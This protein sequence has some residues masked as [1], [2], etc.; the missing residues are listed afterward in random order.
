MKRLALRSF[1]RPSSFFLRTSSFFLAFAA[2]SA[3]AKADPADPQITSY[4]VSQDSRRVVSVAY[5]LDEPA[6]VTMDVLTNGVSIGGQNI[7]NVVGDC[8]KLVPAGAHTIQW[9][10]RVS[11]PD[12]RFDGN[13]VTV[14]LTASA[15]DVP[16][17]VMDIDLETKAVAYYP[18]MDYLPD[19]GLANDKYRTTH[20]V[21][22][23]V[24]AAGQTFT[25]GSPTDENP[26]R[27]ATEV[28]HSVSFTKDYYL[29]IYETT[30]KQFTTM[31]CTVAANY[32]AQD[33]P[34]PGD[35]ADQTPIGRIL[36]NNLRGTVENGIDWPGTGSTVYG[37]S[38][39]ATIRT[40]TG[41][42][43]DLPTEAQ[44]EF[45]CRAGTTTAMYNGK[46][47]AGT[48][49][50]SDCNDIAWYTGTSEQKPHAVGGKLPNDWGFY[51][52]YGN[53]RE[54][55]LDWYATYPDTPVVDPNGPTSGTERVIRSSYYWDG[56]RG[57]RS[58]YRTSQYPRTADTTYGFRLCLPL[59]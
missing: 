59:Q 36:Y 49:G 48:W 25:M 11:W 22:K 13:V 33:D 54:W 52:M 31:G 41:L 5:T 37:D 45:A 12:Q 38:Y 47:N 14:R 3:T 6:Y 20:L 42:A 4:T 21:M 9:F 23:K 50:N 58:A 24:H 7:Q 16:P 2:V 15:A 55:C 1:L 27:L 18:S 10:A 29:A 44:W 30:R 32:G 53:V 17:D 8:F 51:D 34:Y 56:S 35:D 26:N 57:M 46:P 28:Q 40:A 19:G 39:L 43:L